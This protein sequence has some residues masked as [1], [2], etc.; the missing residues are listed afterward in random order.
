V[1]AIACY[2]PTDCVVGE[3]YGHV[4]TSSEKATTPPPEEHAKEEAP[5]GTGGES[6]SSSTGGNTGSGSTTPPTTSSTATSSTGS[7]SG[8]GGVA[9]ISRS[10]VTAGLAASLGSSSGAS[11]TTLL[12]QSQYTLSYQALESGSLLIQWYEIPA[13]AHLA[14]KAKA[15]PVLVASGE[16]SVPASG[17]YAVHIRLTSAGKKLLKSSSHLKL[18]AQATFTPAGGAPITTTKTFTVAKHK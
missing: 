18:I 17:K 13:G 12:K 15:K 10:Q 5:G 7:S 16:V 4:Y 8:A 11:I 1:E 2:D 6:G 14:K 9:T 3:Y